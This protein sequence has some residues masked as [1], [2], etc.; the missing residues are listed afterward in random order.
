MDLDTLAVGVLYVLWG[1][2][3]VV[4]PTTSA[5]HPSEFVRIDLAAP[6]GLLVPEHRRLFPMRVRGADWERVVVPSWGEFVSWKR[7]R[8]LPELIEQLKLEMRKN[9]EA[10]G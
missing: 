2:A 6:L 10:A 3:L 5:A 9:L 8:S 1:R 4:F 7:N